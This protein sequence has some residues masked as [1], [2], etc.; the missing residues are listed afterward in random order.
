MSQAHVQRF[1]LSLKSINILKVPR[2]WCWAPQQ[3]SQDTTVSSF[4][5]SW[6]CVDRRPL[7]ELHAFGQP[8]CG[9][10][11]RLSTYNSS[12]S[13]S[14]SHWSRCCFWKFLPEGLHPSHAVAK[15]C[16]RNVVLPPVHG[17]LSRLQKSR[18]DMAIGERSKPKQLAL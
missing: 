1:K 11:G 7:G 13:P 17:F 2:A 8:I 15:K 4:Q 14:L 6:P 12:N 10:R 3:Q 5:T 9:G 16:S 18:F